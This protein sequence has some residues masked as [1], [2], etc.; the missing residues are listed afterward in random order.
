MKINK[1][2]G[3]IALAAFLQACNLSKDYDMPNYQ[4]LEVIRENTSSDSS[5]FADVKWDEL[6]QDTQLNALIQEAL[7]SNL[8]IN[9]ALANIKSA[10]AMLLQQKGAQLPNASLNVTATQSKL[11]NTISPATGFAQQ[12]YSAYLS[13][14]WEIDIWGK[15]RAAKRSALADLFANQNFLNAVKTRIIAN[16]SGSY[17]QLMAYDAQL[18]LSQ[19]TVEKRAAYVAT[20]KDLK[21]ASLVTEA[22]VQ[23]AEANLAAAKLIIPQIKQAIRSTEN[24]LSVLLMRTPGKIERGVLTEQALSYDFNQ[25]VSALLLG[26][27]PDVMQAEWQLRSAF[28][29]VH[30]ARTQFYPSVT[31]T[32]RGGFV[33]NDPA[34]LFDPT[35][36]FANLAGGL[37]QPIFNKRLNRANLERQKAAQDIALYNY[38]YAFLNAGREVSDALFNF[39]MATEKIAHAQKQTEALQT[40]VSMNEELLTYGKVNYTVVLTSEQQYLNAQLSAIDVQLEKYLS[41][42]EVYRSLGGGWK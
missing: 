10:E 35:S 5:S 3:Y 37:V 14:S 17:Y 39:E 21:Q 29:Q 6:Y 40:A 7:D 25:G 42:I 27:R 12:Q 30:V 8:D 11:A 15:F 36:F 16:V 28:E 33:S 2:I 26:N 1:I 34:A 31:L 18:A 32:G 9:V 22:D 38:K 4:D 23:Q 41:L 24:A 13:A 20:L 19:A